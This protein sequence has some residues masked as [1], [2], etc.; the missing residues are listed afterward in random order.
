MPISKSCKSLTSLSSFHSLS[1]RE[2]VSI[3]NPE[4]PIRVILKFPHLSARVLNT[5]VSGFIYSVA[6][7]L[8]I[9]PIVTL[10]EFPRSGFAAYL[11]V[12]IGP[13][14][15]FT[16]LLNRSAYSLFCSFST[17]THLLIRKVCVKRFKKASFTEE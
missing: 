1:V 2:V 17:I 15:I 3:L 8:P 4:E 13:V 14:I 9:Q 16:F 6:S 10:S 5:F 7:G 12:S 11:E